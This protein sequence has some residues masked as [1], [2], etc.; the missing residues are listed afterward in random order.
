MLIGDGFR[1]MKP[2]I[3]IENVFRNQ[4]HNQIIADVRYI[5]ETN[6]IRNKNGISILLW[7]PNHENNINNA[8]EQEFM[9]FIN[10]LKKLN[11]DGPIPKE[12]EIP[13]NIWLRNDGTK[14]DL[15]NKIDTIVIP[16]LK[17]F[18]E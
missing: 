8:S 18:W 15:Y 12:L 7:R 2:N 17:E 9:P 14:E 5:N 4:K 6:Y 3:W 11:F 10:R 16:Y 13:F 1:K